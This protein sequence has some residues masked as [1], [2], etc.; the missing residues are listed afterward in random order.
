[1]A[2]RRLWF[3][4]GRAAS[5]EGKGYNFDFDFLRSDRLVCTELVYRA[6]DGI[7]NVTI[8][9]SER[10]GRPKLFAEDLLRGQ[11][12]GLPGDGG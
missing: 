5:H 1:V 9:L 12:P 4:L 2:P 3:L 11:L 10:A 7:G 8:P 6:F